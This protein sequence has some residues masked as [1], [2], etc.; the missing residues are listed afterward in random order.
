MTWC[1]FYDQKV[2][3][4]VVRHHA[5]PTQGIL[6]LTV[7]I[8]MPPSGCHMLSPFVCITFSSSQ[9]ANAYS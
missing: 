5:A 9:M 7:S 6:H 8:L 3:N 1:Q 4:L 2:E